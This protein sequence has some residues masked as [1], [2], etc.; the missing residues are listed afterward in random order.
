[1]RGRFDGPRF[2]PA[3]LVALPAAAAA[4]TGGAAAQDRD[5][6]G[7]ASADYVVECPKTRS[8]D[9]ACAADVSTYVGW[10]VFERYCASCHGA[11]AEGSSFAPSLVHR[12][13]RFDRRAFGRALD[14]GY[15]GPFAPMRPW[16]EHPQVARYYD[17]LWAYLSAR[18]NGDLAAG[19]LL[20]LRDRPTE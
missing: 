4:W 20:P 14:E 13:R 16:G 7:G 10:R 6:A 1:M 11:D 12:L 19:P 5:G 3:A 15:A 18:T 9:A 2:V 8:P 17:E